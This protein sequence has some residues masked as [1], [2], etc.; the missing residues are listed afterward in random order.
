MLKRNKKN[1]E[2]FKIKNTEMESLSENELD[3]VYTK[4]EPTIRDPLQFSE[5]SEEYFASNSLWIFSNENKFRIQIQKFV[6]SK[7]FIIIINTIIITNCLFLIFET[8]ENLK[9]AAIYTEYVFTIIFIIEFILKIIAY[10]FILEQYSYLRDPWNWLDFIV[11]IS[12]TINLFPQINAN[13]FAL[14]TIRL[15]RPLKTITVLPHMRNFIVVLFNS[16]IDVGTV[17]LFVFFFCNYF[18]YFWFIFME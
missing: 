10:G 7:I 6:S 17:Y 9:I 14:R 1:L 16:L 15:I 3:I 12:C 5:N 8:I 11:V 4:N 2:L 18:R 13:L